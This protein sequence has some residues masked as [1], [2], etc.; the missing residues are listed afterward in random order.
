MMNFDLKL[1]KAPPPPNHQI[2][3]PQQQTPNDSPPPP[4]T[5]LKKNNNPKPI[6]VYSP[7]LAE[8]SRK[9]RIKVLRY[10][11]KETVYTR[12]LA[13]PRY[14]AHVSIRVQHLAV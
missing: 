4:P 5:L 1:F 9:S 14:I 11:T 8:S 6:P 7:R 10:R 3:D 2:K 12:Y 13:Q